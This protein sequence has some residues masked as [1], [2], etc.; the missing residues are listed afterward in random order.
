MKLAL[1]AVLACTGSCGDNLSGGP[2]DSVPVTTQVTAPGLSAPVD[3]VRDTFG[4]PH[5]YAKTEPD[6]AFANGYIQAGD[7][8]SEMELLRHFAEGRVAELF[9][10]LQPEQIDGDLTMRMHRFRELAQQS[11]DAFQA[12]SDPIDQAIVVELQRYADGANQYV[13][14][15][16]AGQHPLDPEVTVLFDPTRFEPWTPV[17]SLAIGY[18]Q[19]WSLQY[20]DSELSLQSFY[21]A[22]RTA[23]DLST[24]PDRLRRAKAGIDLRSLAPIAPTS[25][26]DGFPNVTADSGTR[27]RLAP[28]AQ[29]PSVPARLLEDGQRA[30]NPASTLFRMLK[31]PKNGSNNWVVSP[32]LA[33][34][35]PILAND[36][37][38]QL[39]NPPVWHLLQITVPGTL[40]V[41]GVSF[42]GI[43]GIIL[44]HNAHVAWGATVVSHDANDFYLET[45]APCASGGGNC[46]QF[47]GHEVRLETF[48][49][50]IKIGA[51]GTITDTKTVTY[52]RVPHHG[53][54]LPIV[55]DHAIVPRT[56]AKAISVRYTGYGPSGAVRALY[57]LNHA[58]SRA[59][60]FAALR[61]FTF[62]GQN[63]VIV[64][65]SGSIGW[66]STNQV[67]LRPAG[68]STFN[69][70]T[71][72]T[73]IAPFFVLPADGSCEWEGF[74]DPRYVPHAIDPAKGFLATANQDPV[75][76]TFDGDPLNGPMVG[77]RPLY[78]G[79][80]YDPGLRESRIT[81]RLEGLAASGKPIAIDDLA[82]IQADT[83]SN[84]G[85]L[86]RPAIVAAVAKLEAEI[87]T[88]GTH[89]DLA[90]FAASLS[91]I[92]KSRLHDAAALLAAWS[93]ETPAAVDP[94]TPAAQITDS[95]AT[96]LF[97]F[98]TGA[99]MNRTF[100]DEEFAM[101]RYAD[102]DRATVLVLVHPEKLA[103]GIATETGE[104]I[105]CDD[106]TTTGTIESC[107][108]QVV[109]ALDQALDR[110]ASSS[111]FG[112]ADPSQWRWGKLHTLTLSPLTPSTLLEIPGS[113][114]PD[115]FLR[116]GYPRPGDNH[117]VDASSFGT[118][119]ASFTYDHGPSMRHITQFDAPGVPHTRMALPGGQIFDRRSPH[120]RD[121]MDLYWSKNQ[122]FD[123][124]FST[125]EIV[126]AA[127]SR[128]QFRGD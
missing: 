35:T 48:T 125:D 62:G 123:L 4:V 92:R 60:A 30:L 32:K 95:A 57:N 43:P 72:P 84:L 119:S 19:Q 124:P 67:P 10:G 109:A 44:G 15:L 91:T 93:L 6:A 37:H 47:Q 33:G 114:D 75:G 74:L 86:L 80:N 89:P 122:Y 87:A 2:F 102:T 85:E 82:A 41:S 49:E 39:I 128:T 3:V 1:V 98:W 45:I 14:E 64:D 71:N 61:D 103:S 99:F 110:A 31:N 104:P 55:K 90:A 11:F 18:L 36:P 88:P 96:V 34:G 13:E 73:G 22:A 65:D 112:T 59:E 115:P 70:K 118:R 56:D 79:W 117:S 116:G 5:I 77:G 78:A 101:G 27:A 21:D 9:G 52:E 97:N 7:R 127:E 68:C 20:D 23:F 106:L 108:L 100:G 81:K 17:D 16:V 121:L 83:H 26:I 54:I 69:A 66:T 63:W 111:G 12:S 40:D 50:T 25:T 94:A 126:T 29:R 53:P 107:T 105:L 8:I 76:E 46:V 58:A 42:P 120:Y 113:D 51:L 24:Q 38:L 28:A